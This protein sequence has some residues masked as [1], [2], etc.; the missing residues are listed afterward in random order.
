MELTHLVTLRFAMQGLELMPEE[1]VSYCHGIGL[2]LLIKSCNK[3]L[4]SILSFIIIFFQFD[5]R[6]LTMGVVLIVSTFQNL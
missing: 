5:S 4:Q 3:Y 2:D 1:E 6:T